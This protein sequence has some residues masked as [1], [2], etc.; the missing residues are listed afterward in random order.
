MLAHILLVVSR[1]GAVKMLGQRQGKS[2]GK[3]VAKCK[4]KWGSYEEEAWGPTAKGQWGPAAQGQWG[5][6]AAAEG[7]ATE[8]DPGRLNRRLLARDCVVKKILRPYAAADGRVLYGESADEELL[9]KASLRSILTAE[10][11]ELSRA[12]AGA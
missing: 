6:P 11:S 12:L 2:K 1:V 5:E 9:N 8:G 7:P 3:G 4:G 10:V